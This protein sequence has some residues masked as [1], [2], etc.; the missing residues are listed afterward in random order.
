MSVNGITGIATKDVYSSYNKT[1]KQTQ[2]V[3]KDGNQSQANAGVVYE[4][5]VTKEA[6]TKKDNS[7]IVKQMQQE[8]EM[9]TQ[10][11]QNIVTEMLTKQAG[12]SKQ[13]N[14]IWSL[15]ASGD[16]TVDQATADK[17]KEEISE[18]G[19][20]GVNQTSDRII[21]FAVA[22]C[23]GDETKLGEMKAAFEKG[24]GKAEEIWGG[25]LP[26]ISYKTYDSVMSKFDELMNKDGSSEIEGN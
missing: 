15:L 14:D 9:R 13:F 7:A 22:L 23:N 1:S 12:A 24:F 11:L 20:W 21:D 17:A 10:Q 26:E 18:D 3:A 25:E 4:S 6:V 16:F 8:L 19:Y 2:E 5:T